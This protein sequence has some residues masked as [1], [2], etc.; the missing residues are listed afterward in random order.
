[1]VTEPSLKCSF[2]A[3]MVVE[4]S[5]TPVTTPLATVATSGLE[6]VHVTPCSEAVKVTV[7]PTKMS[8]SPLAVTVI[9]G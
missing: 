8:F 7:P 5:L 2:E 6:D 3:L 1:M 4:P 9:F